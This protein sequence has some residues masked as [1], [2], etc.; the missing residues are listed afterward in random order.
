[1]YGETFP[2]GKGRFMPVR[3]SAPAAELPSQRFP[4]VL[5]TGRILY[6]WHGG[7]LTRRVSGLVDRASE[8][9]IAVNPQDAARLEIADGEAVV[10]TSRRGEIE[11]VASVT[12]AVRPGETFVPFVQL[13]GAA[14]NFLTNNVYDPTAKIP[15][16]KVCAIRIDKVG[17]PGSWRHGRREKARAR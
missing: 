6:H 12:D 8:L 17:D 15:E 2:R 7:T 10:V 3:Q 14:A 16:Y 13:N 9:R 5:N 1:M 11:A 4:F